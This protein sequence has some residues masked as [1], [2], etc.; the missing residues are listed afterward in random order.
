MSSSSEPPSVEMDLDQPAAE[1]AESAITSVAS[2]SKT[3][4]R[5]DPPAAKKLN[6]A[7]GPDLGPSDT[8]KSKGDTKT[9]RIT[10]RLEY[11]QS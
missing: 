7:P 9:A 8:S 11:W 5:K 1:E 2:P 3:D 10:P 6:A 4:K